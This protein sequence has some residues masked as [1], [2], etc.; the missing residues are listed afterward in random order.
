[1]DG[2]FMR[3]MLKLVLIIVVTVVLI[4]CTGLI[5]EKQSLQQNLIRLHVVANSDS[6]EDQNVK[7]QVKDAIVAYLEPLLEDCHDQKQAKKFLENELPE[8]ERIANVT[9]RQAGVN[10]A[11]KVT[12]KKECFDTRV[13]DTFSLPAGVYDSLRIEIGQANGHNWWCVVFPSLCLQATS[14]EFQDSAVAAGFDEELASTLTMEDGYE[15][16]FYLLDAFGKL[17]NFFFQD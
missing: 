16:R 8:L 17:E 14:Q 10:T 5:A 12:L 3:K 2:V 13:Y 7:L 1:M 11:A 6:E 9:L 15:I 4:K